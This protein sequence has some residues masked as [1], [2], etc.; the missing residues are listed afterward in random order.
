MDTETVLGTLVA[1]TVSAFAGYNLIGHFRYCL[2][3]EKLS[4]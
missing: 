4:V 2:Y 1:P 3:V